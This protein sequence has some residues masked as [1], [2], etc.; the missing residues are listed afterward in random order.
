MRLRETEPLPENL[1]RWSRM[2]TTLLK[3]PV[4][5]QGAA[6]R[7]GRSIGRFER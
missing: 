7:G 5:N 4:E 6:W 3:D 1:D 2:G